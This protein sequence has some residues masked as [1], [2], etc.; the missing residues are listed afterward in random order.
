MSLGGDLDALGQT[1]SV[2]ERRS[3]PGLAGLQLP[4]VLSMA[5]LVPKQP[6]M[7][8]PGLTAARSQS[9]PQSIVLSRGR[10][11]GGELPRPSFS[12]ASRFL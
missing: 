8:N 9:L 1:R 11:R 6:A 4:L 2:R 12:S 10:G 7:L 5:Q 3:W